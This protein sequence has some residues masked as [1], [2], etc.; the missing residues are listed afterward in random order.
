MKYAPGPCFDRDGFLFLVIAYCVKAANNASR[1]KRFSD[2]EAARDFARECR[3]LRAFG[4]PIP[5]HYFIWNEESFVQMGGEI[6]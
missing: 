1:Q 4:G 5:P 3:F 6:I 2:A